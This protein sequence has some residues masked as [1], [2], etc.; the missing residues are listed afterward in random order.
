MASKIDECLSKPVIPV[1]W[2]TA[3]QDSLLARAS[4]VIL[5]AGTLVELRDVVAAFDRP[6][7]QHISVFVHIDLIAGLENS[8]AGLECLA[9]LGRV[10]GV[11][12]IHHNLTRPA[13]K[14]GLLS[15]VRL[16]LSDSR[17]LERGLTIVSKSSADAIEIMPA[18]VAAKTKKDFDRLPLPRIAGGLC[19]SE[20][21][22]QE[23]LASGIRAIT[24]TRP[25]FWEYNA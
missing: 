4:S 23:A 14:L 16:F 24:S 15:V 7:L 1:L 18:A 20:A 6:Q 25:A 12:T 19:R 13:K 17:A 9:A 5:Q 10:A 2:R 22:L 8:E 11:V 21:D 3:N